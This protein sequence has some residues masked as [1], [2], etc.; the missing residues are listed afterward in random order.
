MVQLATEGGLFG[1]VIPT[2]LAEE[3]SFAT[4]DMAKIDADTTS[5]LSKTAAILAET[6]GLPES[7]CPYSARKEVCYYARSWA[8]Q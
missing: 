8:W 6:I 5:D 2:K 4:P 1:G 7:S 3:Y